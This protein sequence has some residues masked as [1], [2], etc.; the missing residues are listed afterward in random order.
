LRG[1]VGRRVTSILL[2]AC[3]VGGSAAAS[4]QGAK[5]KKREIGWA[6]KAEFSY[7]LTSGNAQTTTFSLKNLTR[8]SWARRSFELRLEGLRVRDEETTR[9]AVGTGQD[10][11]VLSETSEVRTTAEKYVA[12]GR[13]DH[14]VTGRLF[15]FAGAGWDRNR[16][17]GIDNRY[18]AFGGLGH[19]LY[20]T[21]KTRFRTDYS[22]TYTEQRDVIPAPE[23]ESHFA[24]LRVSWD[25]FRNLAE[26]TTY[27]NETVIDESLRKTTDWRVDMTNSIAV[28][29]NQHLA[30]KVSLQWLYDNEPAL[31][32]VPLFAP[33]DPT[34]SPIGDVAVPVDEL[35]TIFR[36]SMVVNL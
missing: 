3:V 23:K 19:V 21:E 17:A 6:D 14:Q 7:V 12:S 34:G 4:G 25:Y 5:E 31:A 36:A 33:D 18:T 16:I 11:F 9:R 30:L 24:G 1:R 35:D 20:D 27:G 13:Y 32:E 22:A 8:R 15:W 2:A 28:G 26:G 10:D 29:I